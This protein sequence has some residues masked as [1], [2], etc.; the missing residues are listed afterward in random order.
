M[1]GN[2][3][4]SFVFFM[5]ILLFYLTCGLKVRNNEK[6]ESGS[7]GKEQKFSIGR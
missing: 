3:F 6:A 7:H 1:A 2:S 5:H 4:F